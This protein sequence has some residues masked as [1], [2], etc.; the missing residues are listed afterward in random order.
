MTALT[1]LRVVELGGDVASAYC[2]KL[3]AGF[4]AEVLRVAHPRCERNGPLAPADTD[5]ADWLDTGKKRVAC[6]DDALRDLCASADLIIDGLGPNGLETLGVDTD[7]ERQSRDGR[8]VVR[9]APFG[10]SGPMAHA[11]ASDISLYAASGLMNSTGRGDREPLNAG[12][13]LVQLGAGLRACCAAL[14]ALHRRAHDGQGDLI[15]VSMQETGLDTYE[16]ALV[17]HLR[18]G[19]VARR[20]GDE[21]ALVPWRTFRCRDGWAAVVGGPMRNWGQASALFEDAELSAPRLA[22]MAERI[23]HRQEVYQRMQPWLARTDKRTI[24]HRGQE[25]GQAWTYL[26]TLAD[27]AEDPQF[28]ARGFFTAL[29]PDTPEAGRVPGAP[30]RPERSPWQRRSPPTESHT[31]ARLAGKPSTQWRG[32]GTAIAQPLA[33]LTVL[34][35]THDWAG[36]HAA[37]LLADYGATVIKIEFPARLDGMR[38]AYK[39]RIN[40]HPRVHQLHRN[41]QSITLDLRLAEH[42]EACHRLVQKADIL[43][44]NSRPGVM[45]RKGLAPDTLRQLNPRLIAV[46]LSAFGATGPYARYAGYGGSIEAVSGLQDLT[47]YTDDDERFRVREM[48]V[49]NGV[50]GALAALLGLVQRDHD[51]EGQWIDLAE[52]ETTAWLIGEHFLRYFRLSQEPAPQG[53]SDSRFVLQGCYSCAGEDQWLAL[54]AVDTDQARTLRTLVGGEQALETDVARWCAALDA[55]QAEQR[56]LEA[57][58]PAAQVRSAADLA[59]DA[60][61]KARAWWLKLDDEGFPGMPFRFG[62]G[63]GALHRR[64]PDLGQDNASLLPELGLDSAQWCDLSADALGT[65]YDTEDQRA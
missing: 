30:F 24:F 7:P 46:S 5:S 54:T 15:E 36:P 38:G 20:N 60:H 13:P 9:I 11:A 18:T 41:K 53:N 51:G 4:G 58:I 35:F 52:T 12:F 64:G 39:D 31:A 21:H 16:I 37:R 1:G 26:A 40:A 27:A 22:H 33:G 55:Q 32:D 8:I 19:K 25:A 45:A 56:L 48:D 61:L 42:R 50:F 65:A 34:D 14:M 23:A 62:R 17:E 44:D 6:D 49:L 47:A 43:L 63:G 29:R 10:L 28:S 59:R 57:G 3:L 2:T